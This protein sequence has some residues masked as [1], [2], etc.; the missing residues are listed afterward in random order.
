MRVSIQPVPCTAPSRLLQ[1]ILDVLYFRH[2]LGTLTVYVAEALGN[3]R[4]QSTYPIRGVSDQPP[5]PVAKTATV[6]V[7]SKA[8]GDLRGWAA[9]GLDCNVCCGSCV[10]R[11][12]KTEE[13]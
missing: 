2:I 1:L 5:V 11:S 9:L 13:S 8:E 7:R 10:A 12:S 3:E 6:E 4:E